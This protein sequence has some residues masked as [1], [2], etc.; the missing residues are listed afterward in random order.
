MTDLEFTTHFNNNYSALIA[1]AKR[2]TKNTTDA[3][4]LVQETALKAFKG[5]KTFKKGTSFKSWA[6]TILRNSFITQYNK[7]RKRNTISTPVEEII[8]AVDKNVISINRG[9]STMNVNKINVAI[10]NLSKKVKAPLVL[11]L[12]GYKY[13]DIASE[14]EIPL[15]TV[16]SRINYAKTKLRTSPILNELRRA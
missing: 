12:K 6:F 11:F 5:K 1:F 9:E 8:Y 3:E 13:D 7:R 10:D 16:K 2:F 4:D 14:L 15:G